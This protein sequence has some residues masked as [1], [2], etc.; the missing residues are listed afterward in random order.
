ML[1]HQCDGAQSR[2]VL[3]LQGSKAEIG[4]PQEFDQAVQQRIEVA[5]GNFTIDGILALRSRFTDAWV[6][7]GTTRSNQTVD[8]FSQSS[9]VSRVKGT[10]QSCSLVGKSE[11]VRLQHGKDARIIGAQRMQRLLTGLQVTPSWT[12]G[13]DRVV[14]ACAPAY[15]TEWLR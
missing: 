12:Q 11:K 1:N 15:P 10:K 3:A 8:P 7:K 13:I 4:F 6:A 9:P 14:H 5:V 2:F